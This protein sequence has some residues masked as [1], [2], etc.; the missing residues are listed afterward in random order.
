MGRRV[1]FVLPD[2]FAG[3]SQKVMLALAG[4]LDRRRYEPRVI[5]LNGT[6]PF[7]GRV[8]E[9]VPVTDLGRNAL[10]SAFPA[11]R[12]AL[13][14]AAPDAVVSSMGYLN[15]GVLLLKPALGG[16]TQVIVRE[17]NALLP[18]VRYGARSL[19]LK[20]AYR[21]LYGRASRV[22][23]PSRMLGDELA[24]GYGVDPARVTVLRNAVNV[25][26]QR[27]AAMPVRRRK[28]TEPQF[29][30]V[31][32]LSRQKAY[33]RLLEPIAR[34]GACGH[35]TIFGEG[36]ERGELEALIAALGLGR[37]VTLAG[38][39]ANPAPWVAG[40]DALLLPSLWEGLPNVAL[41]AL[42]VGTPVIATPEA[43]AIGEIA[44]QA[45][46]GAVTIVQMGPDFARAMATVK[47][48]CTGKLR[49]SL[50]PEAFL[51]GTVNARFTSILED[52]FR[53]GG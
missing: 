35:V 39:E 45:E 22:I 25:E 33:G 10:R 46:A 5:V 41:E 24:R 40:A 29:V 28:G 3:G 7:S 32:R 20:L 1:A 48:N 47:R 9:G 27:A 4:G 52:C 12:R 21:A 18:E 34:Q 31:G 51:S 17:A 43:G 6:G 19:A 16:D 8:P 42:S 23:S 26:A 50:L 15:L 14:A 53:R 11:L 38:F 13:R 49:P 30:C 2:F 44:E 36:S 37:Q